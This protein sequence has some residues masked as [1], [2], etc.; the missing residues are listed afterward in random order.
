MIKKRNEN[1]FVYNYR[2]CFNFLGELKWYF[3]FS[4]EIFC[5]FFLIG[6][7]FPVFFREQLISL[8]SDLASS[9]E[10]KSTI[11]IILYIFLNNV[12]ASLLS[13]ILGIGLAV[14]PFITLVF[15]GYLLGFIGKEVVIREGFF[16]LWRIFPHGI[17]EL[18]AIFFSTGIGLKIGIEIFTKKKSMKYNYTE[19]VRFFLFVVIPLLI[20]AA[21]I[22]GMLIMLI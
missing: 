20:V 6:F 18:P 14:F 21:I 3:V 2:Q 1:F 10:G 5:L 9:I 19:G 15:N 12:Q 13:F 4:I 22:E 8:I 7:I 16:S 17:F 11:G